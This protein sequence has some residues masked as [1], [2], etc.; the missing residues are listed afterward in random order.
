MPSGGTAQSTRGTSS[1]RTTP[2][3]PGR[4]SFGLLRRE[5]GFSIASL[6]AS[7]PIAGRSRLSGGS[8]GGGEEAGQQMMSVSR[9]G[10][11][12]PKVMAKPYE[13][14]ED[15]EEGDEEGESV[16]SKDE[17]E[18]DEESKGEPDVEPEVL[19][20]DGRRIRSFESMLSGA[21]KEKQK[22]LVVDG[23]Q[24]PRKTLSDRLASMSAL[25]TSTLKGSPP[26]SR[27][28]STHVSHQRSKSAMSAVSSS[29]P[30][31]PD[32]HATMAQRLKLAPPK[33]RFMEC[34][35]DELKLSEIGEL[36]REYRRL[37]DGIRAA[38][39]FDG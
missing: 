29:R 23:L 38:G 9:P 13:E 39:G 1:G 6:A 18:D 34:T 33:E 26:D 30:E 10:S 2:G 20:G 5:S 7:L 22:S 12:S 25:A 36:L 24:Q 37:A 17:S 32:G 31:S 3:T 35:V 4:A 21:N 15:D 8:T 14:A 11:R 28:S 27:G 19:S 16:S